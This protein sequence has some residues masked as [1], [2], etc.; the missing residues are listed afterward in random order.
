MLRFQKDVVDYA[1]QQKIRRKL[2]RHA[3]VVCCTL[4]GS[5]SSQ[6]ADDLAPT[7]ADPHGAQF[8]C[9]IVDEVNNFS[10]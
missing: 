7:P 9:I 4:N 8:T 2:I 5:G 6:L 10:Q 3:D 1:R